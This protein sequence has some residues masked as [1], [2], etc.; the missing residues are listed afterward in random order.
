MTI[1]P[2]WGGQPALAATSNSFRPQ[3]VFHRLQSRVRELNRLANAGSVDDIFQ[4]RAKEAIGFYRELEA[5]QTLPVGSVRSD[6][7]LPLLSNEGT[8]HDGLRR[9]NSIIDQ[10][11]RTISSLPADTSITP[12]IR[13]SDEGAGDRQSWVGH[14]R[15]NIAGAE[16]T[17]RAMMS[18]S[19]ERAGIERQ[20][21]NAL[22]GKLW[23]KDWLDS[24]K[25]AIIDGAPVEQG[26]LVPLDEVWVRPY[27]NAL[28]VAGLAT[29]SALAILDKG[30]HQHLLGHISASMPQERLNEAIRSAFPTLAMKHIFVLPGSALSKES[31]VRILAAL[32]AVGVTKLES[33]VRLVMT[34]GGAQFPSLLLYKGQLYSKPERFVSR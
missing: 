30:G 25:A 3:L 21:R 9:L 6:S 27:R 12:E 11:G 22:A 29:E 5:A 17:L 8:V 34:P 32:Q 23:S 28:A 18:K 24:Q 15:A 20:R 2:F 10:L 31:I 14:F 1:G 4:D 16:E 33:S 7:L 13:E 19:E 26:E